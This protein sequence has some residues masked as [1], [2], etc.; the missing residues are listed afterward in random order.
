MNTTVWE[1]KHLDAKIKIYM[2]VNIFKLQHFIKTLSIIKFFSKKKYSINSIYYIIAI[3]FN[4]G[5]KWCIIL[6]E[7]A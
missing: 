7:L 2:L 6:N 4:P 3:G 5:F 1:Q